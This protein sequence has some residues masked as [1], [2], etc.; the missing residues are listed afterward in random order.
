[1]KFQDDIEAGRRNRK[2]GISLHEQ[3]Q[4]YREKLLQ[5]VN[6]YFNF[7]FS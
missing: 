5:K 3:I 4:K 2:S 7:L 1:M 6:N